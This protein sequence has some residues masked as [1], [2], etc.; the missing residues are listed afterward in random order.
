MS[1]FRCIDCGTILWLV[2][3]ILEG[4]EKRPRETVRDLHLSIV[5]L[6]PQAQ[7]SLRGM[8]QEKMET[9]K[10]LKSE[11]SIIQDFE[12]L[13]NFVEE[14]DLYGFEV[15]VQDFSPQFQVPVMSSVEEIEL[16]LD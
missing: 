1:S 15:V 6:E 4:K 9:D 8:I 5:K 16:V 7:A 10:L 14:N 11:S 13:T 3:L 2:P 12:R